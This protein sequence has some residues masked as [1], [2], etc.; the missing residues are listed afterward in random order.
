MFYSLVFQDHQKAF[1][2]AKPHK[3]KQ[4]SYC[5]FIPKVISY[6][7]TKHNP[8]LTPSSS[9][10]FSSIQ[11]KQTDPSSTTYL[12]G[13][14]CSFIFSLATFELAIYLLHCMCFS[15]LLTSHWTVSNSWS[16][17]KDMQTAALPCCNTEPHQTVLLNDHTWKPGVRKLGQH[18]FKKKEQNPGGVGGGTGKRGVL[19]SKTILAMDKD[20]CNCYKE[21]ELKTSYYPI[22][23]VR[24]VL[25]VTVSKITWTLLLCMG[26]KYENNFVYIW[27]KVTKKCCNCDLICACNS[28]TVLTSGDKKNKQVTLYL[29]VT[30]TITLLFFL[31]CCLKN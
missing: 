5:W 30:T 20:Y 17:I 21:A 23:S 12:Q 3:H 25:C 1:M 24:H 4:V 26:Q 14:Y 29:S 27:V 11:V 9:K 2:T 15:Y 19:Y 22:K 13:L 10:Q 6:S 28:N 7:L 31:L 16:Y 8:M 18:P